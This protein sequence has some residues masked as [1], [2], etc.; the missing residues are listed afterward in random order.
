MVKKKGIN[1]TMSLEEGESAP[2]I[3]ADDLPD[4]VFQESEIEE[5]TDYDS[6][7]SAAQ[8]IRRQTEIVGYILKSEEKATVDLNEPTR[9]IEYALLSSQAF[10]SSEAIASSFDLGAAETIVVEGKNLKALCIDLGPNKISVFMKKS[11]DHSYLVN[12]LKSIVYGCFES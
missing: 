10:E 11:A 1:D 6:L 4:V 9:M 3:D 7:L 12:A 2:I 5:E 8:E